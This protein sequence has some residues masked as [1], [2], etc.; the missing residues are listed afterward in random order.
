MAQCSDYEVM[1]GCILKSYELV[2]EAY[3]QKFKNYQMFGQQ[4]CVEF[5]QQ[6]QHFFDRWYSS[7]NISDNFEKLRQLILLE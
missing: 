3:R 6:K 2:P 7:M 5:A 4:T 1:K